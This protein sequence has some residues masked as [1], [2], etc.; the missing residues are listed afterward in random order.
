M[1]GEIA[2]EQGK[3]FQFLAKV[4]M[5]DQDIQKLEKEKEEI[6]EQAEQVIKD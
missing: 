4:K 3:N 6:L 2:A 5:R 1:K